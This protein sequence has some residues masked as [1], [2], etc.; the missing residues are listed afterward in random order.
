MSVF[1]KPEDIRITED[2]PNEQISER[3]TEC[4]SNNRA[5]IQPKNFPINVKTNKEV[6][7]QRLKSK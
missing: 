6:L 7:G 2:M 1:E 5:I 4:S 3:R